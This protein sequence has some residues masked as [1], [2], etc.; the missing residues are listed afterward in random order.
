VINY[1]G[2]G[3]KLGEVLRTFT[4]CSKSS[5]SFPRKN[6]NTEQFAHI[7]FLAENEDQFLLD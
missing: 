2:K 1:F 3:K 7:C 6:I 5:V 4:A